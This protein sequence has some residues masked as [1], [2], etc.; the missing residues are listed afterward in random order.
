MFQRGHPRARRDARS[1][2]DAA[3]VCS[4]HA[5]YRGQRLRTSRAALQSDHH[6]RSPPLNHALKTLLPLT[7]S[8]PV[9][10]AMIFEYVLDSISS[11]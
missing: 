1:P 6:Q 8:A 4:M 9:L 2:P 11:A 7:T 10:A 3:K 5:I